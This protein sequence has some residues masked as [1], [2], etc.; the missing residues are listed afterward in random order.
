[1]MAMGL[2]ENLLLAVGLSMDALAVS[3]C[4]G[5]SGRVNSGR[6]RFRLAANFGIFQALMPIIG[7]YGGTF[8]AKFIGAFDHWVA[9]GLLAFVGGRM[10]FN[11]FKKET[12]GGTCTLLTTREE[13]LLGVATSIDALAVGLSLAVLGVSIWRPSINIGVVTAGITLAALLLGSRLGTLFGKR[14]EVFGGLVL[15]AI[16]LRVLLTHL[17]GN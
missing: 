9:F 17:L 6:G 13:L 10:I 4:M 5:A 12:E 15:V 3:L 16:G 2:L 8:L 1:M 7:W 14:A 11:G